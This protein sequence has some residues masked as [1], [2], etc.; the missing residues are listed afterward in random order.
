MSAWPISEQAMGPP[1][2]GWLE[3]QGWDVFQ[4][5]MEGAGGGV[6]DIVARRGPLTWAI[7]MKTSMKLDL[8]G[9]ALCWRWKANLVSVAVPYRQVGYA[10]RIL[11]D[12]GIGLLL[13]SDPAHESYGEGPIREAI[14]AA[15]CRTRAKTLRDALRPEQK[16]FAAAGSTGS[17]HF[18]PFKATCLEVQ[19]VVATSPGLTVKELIDQIKHHY[20]T[21]ASA[22]S[23]LF[24]WIDSGHIKG[25]E[26]R[27]EG[28]CARVYP[29]PGPIATPKEPSC[30]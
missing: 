24:K 3:A 19:R 15:L 25:V 30:L 12:Y 17:G 8:I 13:V 1:L 16:V 7:E 14:P 2:I 26:L 11:T 18:T 21:K 29:I 4:E 10:K 6:C 27:H 28:R 9:Q 5:V 23:S 22:R 20:Q